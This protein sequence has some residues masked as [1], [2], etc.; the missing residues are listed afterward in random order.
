MDPNE[1]KGW[2]KIIT[3]EDLDGHMADVGQAETNA[4]L[5]L[6]MLN[7]FPL[8]E[9][10]KL[11]VP[12]CGTGQMF[13]YVKPNQLGPYEYTF[14]DLNPNFIRKL[15]ERISKYHNVKYQTK[16]D[17]IEA[18]QLTGHYDG[19]LT[20]LVLQHIEW[21]KG[22]ESM[23]GLTPE[24]MYFIIQQQ[25]NAKHA[26]TKERKLRPSIAQ[27]A[28]IANPRLVARQELIDFLRTMDYG[29]VKLYGRSV[30]DNKIMA[31]LVFEKGF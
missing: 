9:G 23:A 7:E 12:G 25:E 16:E 26:I 20:V 11:L 17:D 27:F 5:V 18:T 24:R 3:P 21:Q 10:A 28:E 31:G 29:I 2:T 19:T 15:E 14:T 8:K 22:I 4:N 1:R 13:D 6:Q 30:P